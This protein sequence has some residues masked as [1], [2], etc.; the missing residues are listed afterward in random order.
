MRIWSVAPSRIPPT[1]IP[2]IPAARVE[3]NAVVATTPPP[4][5]MPLGTITS[6][7]RV[8][9]AIPVLRPVDVI[10]FVELYVLNCR[11]GVV[12]KIEML[13]VY[14]GFGLVV[15][16]LSIGG[17]SELLRATPVLSF[18]GDFDSV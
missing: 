3:H 16:R 2:V 7:G 13:R 15:V 6:E 8:A 10:V 9:L 5:I 1:R 11:V 18:F 17:C 14:L 4:L 12:R